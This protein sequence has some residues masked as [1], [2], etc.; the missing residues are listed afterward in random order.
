VSLR[1]PEK[2]VK[3]TVS[4]IMTQYEANALESAYRIARPANKTTM[5]GFKFAAAEP[6]RDQWDKLP[7]PS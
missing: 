1:V 6:F 4:F 3:R 7:S 2:G 5:P